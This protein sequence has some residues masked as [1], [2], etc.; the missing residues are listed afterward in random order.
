MVVGLMH[1]VYCLMGSKEEEEDAREVAKDAAKASGATIKRAMAA[2]DAAG[3][4]RD[5]IQRFLTE[6]PAPNTENIVGYNH[7]ACWPRDAGSR[8][9]RVAFTLAAPAAA[10]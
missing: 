7:K 9:A 3:E 2:L 5:L 6:H 1:W 8:F 4:A 10:A